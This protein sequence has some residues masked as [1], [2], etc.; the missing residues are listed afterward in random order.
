MKR[1]IYLIFILYSCAALSMNGQK[2][3]TLEECRE[4]A[5]ENNKQIAISAQTKEKASTDVKAYR[6]NFLPKFSLSG[7]YLLSNASSSLTI[8]GGYLPTYVPGTDGTLVPNLLTASSE[9]PVFNLYAYM[10]DT[11][12][13]IK[14]SN[15]YTAS[16]IAEQPIY[17]G[18]KITSAYRMARIGQE[19]ASLSGR[20]SRSEVLLT[21]D[22]A[23][24]NYVKAFE[25]HKVAEKYQKTV[26]ELLRNVR[27]GEEVGLLQRNNVLKVQVKLN[28][29]EL[30]VRKTENAIR[31][32]RMNLCHVI[33]LPLNTDIALPESFET[34]NE[35]VSYESTITQ[36]P[37][38]EMLAKQ[39]EFKHQQTKLVRSEFMPNIGLAAMYNYTYGVKV[40]DQPFFDNTSFAAVLSVKIPLF[41]WGEGRNKVR[42]AKTEQKISELNQADAN[43]KME[44][45]LMKA[46]NEVDEASLEVELT[47]HALAEA[48]ENLKTHKDM[49][50]TGMA[51]LADYLEAQTA[52]QKAG[53]DEVNAK[54]ALRLSLTRYNKAAG[55]L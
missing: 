43:E 36:R 12:F 48:E 51:T 21:T 19:I 17:M 23:Y 47:R 31:L 54:A 53:A 4:M 49:Y 24:W 6:A 38:Y 7:G 5:L 10:P 11:E 3:M 45:E 28:E 44:L 50:E 18:G 22:E 13:R 52:W 16:V 33:G 55:K 9:N 20:L 40:N 1:S 8:P 41:Q 46:I 26:N 27:A 15:S 34:P 14:L 25:L 35:L 30:Q 32:A 2:V 37:E 29:A 42:S 39:V